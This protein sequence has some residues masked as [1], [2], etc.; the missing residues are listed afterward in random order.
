MLLVSDF[1]T[2]FKADAP[3]PLACTSQATIAH[4]A[5]CMP[6]ARAA[7]FMLQQPE[8]AIKLEISADMDL[9]DTVPIFFGASPLVGAHMLSSGNAE[10]V[11]CGE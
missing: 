6:A 9:K 1:F 10:F 5:T 11:Y 3:T 4:P 8:N 2:P 7:P